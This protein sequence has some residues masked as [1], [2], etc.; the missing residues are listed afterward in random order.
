L[1]H[2][3]DSLKFLTSLKEVAF[4]FGETKIKTDSGFLSLIHAIKNLKSLEKLQFFLYGKKVM[5]SKESALKFIDMISQH[6]TLRELRHK[7]NSNAFDS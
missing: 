3:G 1:K 4:H 2:F 7:I 5:I 6:E